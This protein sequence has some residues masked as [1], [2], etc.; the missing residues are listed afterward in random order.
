MCAQFGLQILGQWYTST[1]FKKKKQKKK[2]QHFS[3]NTQFK[4]IIEVEQYLNLITL[5]EQRQFLES[6]LSSF[7]SMFIS[8]H[9][10]INPIKLDSWC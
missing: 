5:K 7:Y 3:K 4:T 2:T 6:I 9:Y 8:N 1:K 10:F